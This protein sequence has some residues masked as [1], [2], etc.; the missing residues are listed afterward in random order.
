MVSRLMEGLEGAS[1]TM[2]NEGGAAAFFTSM[3]G[4]M[5]GSEW[6]SATGTGSGSGSGSGS[7]S[8]SD[9]GLGSGSGSG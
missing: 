6:L 1:S 4:V 8:G 3:T 7:R 9:S 2:G 5:F